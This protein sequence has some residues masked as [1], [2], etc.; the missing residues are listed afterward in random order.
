MRTAS[1]SRAM[2]PPILA[3]RSESTNKRSTSNLPGGGCGAVRQM[4]YCPQI[5]RQPGGSL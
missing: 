3:R 4:L 5:R 1:L 2:S